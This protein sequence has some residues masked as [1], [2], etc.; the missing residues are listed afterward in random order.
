MAI[1]IKSKAT[2]LFFLSSTVAT[3]SAFLP[4]PFSS[5]RP[6]HYYTQSRSASL[7][8]VAATPITPSSIQPANSTSDEGN[9]N[10]SNE[11]KKKYPQF[12][13]LHEANTALDGLANQCADLKEPVITRADEC[14]SQWEEMRNSELEPD[15]V[16]FNTVLK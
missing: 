12:K 15:T 5:G 11:Q 16:S 8:P 7:L 3:T 6:A 14:Q 4:V 1:F 2:W 10:S 9:N 13:D